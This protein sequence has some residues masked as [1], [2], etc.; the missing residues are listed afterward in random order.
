MLAGEHIEPK[1][2]PV[3]FSKLFVCLLNKEFA[4]SQTRVRFSQGK[5]PSCLSFYTL[6]IS[7]EVKV[8][9]DDFD[10][11]KSLFLPVEVRFRKSPDHEIEQAEYFHFHPVGQKNTVDRVKSTTLSKIPGTDN[12]IVN[13]KSPRDGLNT[14]THASAQ[15]GQDIW[16]DPR[17]VGPLF[18]S[19]RLAQT[20]NDSVF[21]GDF[22]LVET[23]VS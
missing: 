13:L 11:G 17:A 20:I 22:N 6:M 5:L 8:L 19:A 23:S 21:A 3:F 9:L 18:F 1:S 4:S 2:T 15:N 14:F 7:K 12:F 16:V 10:V